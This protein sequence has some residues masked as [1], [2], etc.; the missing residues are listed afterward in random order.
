MAKS[1]T[2]RQLDDH[3]RRENIRNVVILTD[4]NVDHLYG[5]YFSELSEQVAVDKLVLR[6]GEKTKS[7]QT[8]AQVWNYL[9]EKQYDKN[10]EHT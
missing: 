4:K 10:T 7:I 5:D 2:I 9:A 1:D 6:P 3:F 8:A